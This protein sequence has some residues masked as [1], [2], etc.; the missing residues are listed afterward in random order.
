MVI[1]SRSRC[2]NNINKKYETTVT[3][4]YKN[5]NYVVYFCSSDCMKI[6]NK[7]EKCQ[8]CNYS[9]DIVISQ[10]NKLAYCTRN[11]YGNITC[12]KKYLN[13]DAKKEKV[14]ELINLLNSYDFKTVEN[15]IFTD[16][17]II[18]IHDITEHIINKLIPTN[19]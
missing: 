2:E 5:N 13:G 4:Y 14:K 15:N 9:G 11:L 19:I 8:Y 10:Q 16:E 3:G 18:T 1:C 12:Y 6:F 7:T 17:D